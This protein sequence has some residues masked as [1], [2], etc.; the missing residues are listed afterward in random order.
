[1]NI[2]LIIILG[3][4]LLATFYYGF[5]YIWSCVTR[6]F[7]EQFAGRKEWYRLISESR[8]EDT[9][10]SIKQQMAAVRALS[11]DINSPSKFAY[12]RERATVSFLWVHNEHT[13]EW[14]LHIC[15]TSNVRRSTIN[16]LAR[17]INCVVDPLK[18]QPEI[19]VVGV[20]AARTRRV[21][22]NVGAI[23]TSLGEVAKRISDSPQT[24]AFIMTMETMQD[25]E[26]DRYERYYREET[27]RRG[28][29]SAEWH[30]GADTGFG[31][32]VDSAM[33]ASFCA[34]SDTG[35]SRDSELLL[36]NAMGGISTLT[37]GY[38]KYSPLG[39]TSAVA[40]SWWMIYILFAG[41]VTIGVHLA[42]PELIVIPYLFLGFG[43]IMALFSLSV[44]RPIVR[45]QL[46][47]WLLRGEMV[48]KPHHLFSFSYILRQQFNFRRFIGIGRKHED[49]RDG[50][51]APSSR[52]IFTVH[53]AAIAEVISVPTDQRVMNVA[54]MPPMV[55]APAAVE[56]IHG[57][58]SS[59][60]G[61]DG[62]REP[63]TMLLDTLNY[64]VATL[65]SPGS[66]KTNFLQ[67]LF[68]NT[69]IMCR[70]NEYG[71]K[72][73]PIWGEASK[74]EG[75]YDAWRLVHDMHPNALMV[76]THNPASSYRLALEGPRLSDGISPHDVVKNCRSLT[77]TMQYA[78]GEDIK[79]ASREFL[80]YV[81]RICMLL[82]PEEIE[83]LGLG[84][85]VDAKRPNI[86]RL[87]L[88][89]MASNPTIDPGPKLLSWLDDLRD[90]RAHDDRKRYLYDS[91][92]D[93][94]QFLDPK[95]RRLTM[96]RAMAP[97][98]KLTDL[99]TAE[100]M[101]TPRPEKEDV[102]IGSI[103]NNFAP[104]VINMASYW[105]A[106][107]GQYYSVSTDLSRR[108]LRMYVFAQWAYI[109][110]NC[111]GWERMGRY[112]P[113][114]F[115]EV[116]DVASQPAGE[117]SNVVQSVSIRGR[118]Y[119][120]SMNIGAQDL[121]QVPPDV[122]HQ[123]LGYRNRM[124]FGMENSNDLKIGYQSL[125]SGDERARSNYSQENLESLPKG[126]A[127]AK[128]Y[129][130]ERTTVPFTL[131]VPE[132]KKYIDLLKSTGDPEMAIARFDENYGYTKANLS[133]VR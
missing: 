24:G 110:T 113:T 132:V 111:M 70:N 30:A 54:A 126:M 78:W 95:N 42:A 102:Y 131:L 64:G 18:R 79:A 46:Y 8:S 128:I 81:F 27:I 22:K 43:A 72:I 60:I 12:F 73:T 106:P 9:G 48:M 38:A 68:A 21:K 2:V 56:G 26:V 101:W 104:V 52:S 6:S 51:A 61:K 53:S 74:G 66:G 71:Y 122:L 129:H 45:S 118:S 40:F 19:P 63:I 33:R 83:D 98:N 35:S 130:D 62:N 37:S 16:A 34:I 112:I 3:I 125:V 25:Y 76:D 89:I 120:H 100:E 107:A 44:Y 28:G 32:A 4:P 23:P 20:A 91:I 13:R 47:K 115:D 109:E 119:G 121:D 59:F 29:R 85:L 7:R 77:A 69:S 92:L 123:L 10:S 108:C 105:D 94:S 49:V 93:L 36:G 117:M 14:D 5:S 31:D 17:S 133:G 80:D 97:R 50:I 84:D 55:A 87:S 127:I 124:W 88:L 58:S 41:L 86:I 82:L 114:Y 96:E 57:R 11:N 15:C 1:M 103:V 99:V 39:H 65:G 67:L 75:A 116:R 90:E